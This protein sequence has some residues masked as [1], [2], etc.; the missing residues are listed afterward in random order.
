MSVIFTTVTAG[1]CL[2]LLLQDAPISRAAVVRTQKTPTIITVGLGHRPHSA[3]KLRDLRTLRERRS[4]ANVDT[5]ATPTVALKNFEDGEYYGPV[6]MGTPPQSFLVIYDTGSSNLW[7]PSSRCDSPVFPACSNHSKY[8]RTK[9]STYKACTNAGGCELFLP[10]GSGVVFGDIVEDTCDM[11][12]ITI[13]NQLFGEATIEPGEIWIESPFDGILGLAFPEISLPPGVTP[14]FDM[15]YKQGL[16]DKFQFSFYLSTLAGKPDDG[17]SALVLGGVDEKYCANGQCDWTYHSLDVMQKL[18][19]YWL[20]KSNDILVNGTS[21]GLCPKGCQTVVDTG[22]SILVG[23]NNR[24]NPLIQQ[25]NKSGLIQ[26]DGTMPCDLESS[27]PVLTFEFAEKSYTL[28]PSWYVLKGQTTNAET[29]EKEI[30]CQLGIQGL[31]PL[32][33][34]ELWILGDPFLRKYYTVFDRTA[35]RVGFT[36]AANP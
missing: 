25:C 26:K 23:P 3:K 6:T 16:I 13:Q 30:E 31:N 17:R 32:L 36:L 28:E 27:L 5:A 24:V 10:Y 11:G 33:S 7:V 4:N 12:G 35:N 22:T 34:G 8:D 21:L 9:S 19:G 14:P 1:L 2:A 18:L 20:I 29:G 15:M